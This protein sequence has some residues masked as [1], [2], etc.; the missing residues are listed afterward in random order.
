MAN[1]HSNDPYV[2]FDIVPETAFGTDPGTGYLRVPFRRH[3][4]LA[5][6][7]KD[8]EISREIRP[9]AGVSSSDYGTAE[10]EFEFTTYTYYNAPWYH[11]LLCAAMGG[12]EHIVLDRSV[13]GT[14]IT[15]AN[16]HLYAPQSYACKTAGSI[17]GMPPGM[18]MRAWKAGPNNTVGSIAKVTGA[19]IREIE[20]LQEKGGWLLTRF[21]GVANPLTRV[22]ATGLTPPA[23]VAAHKVTPQDIKVAAGGSPAS[24]IQVGGAEY[25]LDAFSIRMSTAMER[26][27]PYA[28]DPTGNY[29][30]GIRGNRKV[31][32]FLEG[33]VIQTSLDS[34][35][36]LRDFLD[37]IKDREIRMRF[38]SGTIGGG[39]GY[40]YLPTAFGGL[41]PYM[42]DI[43]LGKTIW[44]EGTD[45][46][47]GQGGSIPLRIGFKAYERHYTDTSTIAYTSGI[48]DPDSYKAPILIQLLAD[49]TEDSDARFTA[50]AAGGN[51]LDAT[52]RA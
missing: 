5:L 13:A 3:N 26:P 35:K 41:H 16:T 51:Q 24:F 10:T 42:F 17:G 8:T 6:R 46:I 2:A 32:G 34:G 29:N 9:F 20:F 4:G 18:T 45:P 1:A 22:D 25:E 30:P 39:A 49:T 43:F 7:R 37:G 21:S 50:S 11:K 44:T 47:E 23:I 15:D 27:T 19:R 14:A 12:M 38:M 33:R 52:L 48:G 28:N 40:P 36:P 31:T